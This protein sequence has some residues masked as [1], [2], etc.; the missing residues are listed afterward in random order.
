MVPDT[1]LS[2]SGKTTDGEGGDNHPTV[3]L[4]A[5]VSNHPGPI[6]GLSSPSPSESRHGNTPNRSI[7]YHEAGSSRAGC[8]AH[9]RESF[10]SQG[11][12]AAASDLL[13]S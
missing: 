1:L 10:T 6:G 7:V 8:M 4:P 9:L 13:S 12:S 11:I 3:E 2:V 5:M